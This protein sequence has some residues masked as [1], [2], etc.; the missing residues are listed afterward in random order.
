MLFV[1]RMI[2]RMTPESEF[3]K[4]IA[5]MAQSIDNHDVIINKS[6]P[7]YKQYYQPELGYISGD[8]L[9]YGMAITIMVNRV[10]KANTGDTSGLGFKF[11]PGEFNEFNSDVLDWLDGLAKENSVPDIG[12][13]ILQKTKLSIKNNYTLLISALGELINWE[14]YYTQRVGYYKMEKEKD[15]YLKGDFDQEDEELIKIR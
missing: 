9:L 1:E 5:N 4:I 14:G 15:R 6:R 12:T 11:I 2:Q 13:L 3:C 7:I 10:R 8:E